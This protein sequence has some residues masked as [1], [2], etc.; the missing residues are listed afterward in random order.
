MS[1]PTQAASTR[2]FWRFGL[3]SLLLGVTVVCLWMAFLGNSARRQ[4]LVVA[5][6][7][8][9]GGTIRYDFQ[10]VATPGK[11]PG[12]SLDLNAEPPEPGWLLKLIGFGYFHNV[13]AVG[14]SGGGLT[15]SELALLAQLP[16]LKWVSLCETKIVDDRRKLV[17]PIQDADLAV[18]KNLTELECLNLQG[19]DIH[20]PGF[21][22]LAK[23]QRL[24]EIDL[25]GVPLGDEGMKWIG[26]LTALREL[27]HEAPDKK[28]I[29][30]ITD[31]GL[32]AI[33]NLSNLELL[34]L[35]WTQVS[36][37]GI[38]YLKTMKKLR[39]VDLEETQVTPAGIRM[40][41]K[42]LPKA[43]ISGPLE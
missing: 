17:R 43:S 41:Q 38:S 3:R 40:L 36:D 2:R 28:G 19:A 20:G 30:V 34:E 42:A 12:W 27:R 13:A 6:L 39:D 32:A 23:L 11:A 31:A 16:K 10:V 8:K 35:E 37:A 21:E 7:E 15:E 9:A 26:Q 29:P 24:Q 5:A 1:N 33:T 25:V 18:L 22:Y 4:N 14:F